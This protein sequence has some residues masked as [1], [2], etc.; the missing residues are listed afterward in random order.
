MMEKNQQPQTLRWV[1]MGV[2]GCGKSKVGGALAQRLGIEHVE[3][4]SDHP[5]A[6]IAKMAAGMPLD[7]TDRHGWLLLLQR[8]INEAA[9]AGRGLVLSCSALKRRYRD[10][11]RAGDPNL[12]FL[13]LHGDRD[14]IAKRMQ[15]RADHFMPVTL[16]DSQFRDLEPLQPDEFGLRVDIG[17]PPDALI[18]QALR[19]LQQQQQQH[20]QQ[21]T[22]GEEK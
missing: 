6:N 1:V 5:P 8:R 16:L 11:L 4:D 21:Q 19:H 22:S 18:D 15:A 12:F 10:L 17:N 14:L 20:E 3:G 9:N 2:S 7:D 13:H